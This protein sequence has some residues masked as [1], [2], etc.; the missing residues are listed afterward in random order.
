M[1][2]VPFESFGAVSYS[3]SIVTGAILYH[4]RDIVVENLEIFIPHLYLSPPPPPRR[5][6]P[7]RNFAKMFDNHKTTMSAL[8]CG[9]ET[10]PYNNALSRFVTDGRTDG[11]TDRQAGG[12]NCY[13]NMRVRVVRNAPAVKN[14]QINKNSRSCSARFLTHTGS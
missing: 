11:W 5:G 14:T 4:L 6:W 12:Q 13:S 9:E 3:P 8:S 10:R 7:C 1:K 2:L